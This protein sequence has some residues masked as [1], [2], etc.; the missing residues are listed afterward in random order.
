MAFGP[1]S[2]RGESSGDGCVVYHAFDCDQGR[3]PAPAKGLPS[4]IFHNPAA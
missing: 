3:L 2:S 1:D 4:T